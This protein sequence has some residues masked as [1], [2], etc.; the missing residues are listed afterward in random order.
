LRAYYRNTV[1]EFLKASPSEVAFALVDQNGKFGFSELKTDAVD[2]WRD[3]IMLLQSQLSQLS[4][5]LTDS[6]RWGL[7]LEF[8][9]PRRQRRIDVVLLAGQLIFV[10]EFKSGRSAASTAGKRQVEDYALDLAYFHQPSHSCVVVPVLIAPELQLEAPCKV[11]GNVRTVGTA[12]PN[13]LA[14]LLLLVAEAESSARHPEPSLEQWDDGAYEPVPTVIEAAISLYEGMSVREIARSHAG[15]ED[16]AHVANFLL[17]SIRDAQLNRQ[18]VICF[19]TGIPGAG[20]TLAGL[21]FVHNQDIRGEGRPVP[22]FLSGNGPLIKVLQEA[23]ARNFKKRNNST[24]REAKT[25]V[26][27][28]VQ[29]VHTFVKSH[30][31]EKAA[32]YENAIVF[33]E[34]QRAW[35]EKK[36]QKE[37]E[38]RNEN[39]QVSEPEMILKIMDRHQDWAF[40]VA[41]VGAGQEI[42]EGEAGLSEWGRA[43]VKYPHWRIFISPE[44]LKGGKGIEG[45]ALFENALSTNDI[46]EQPALHLNVSVRS[47]QAAALSDWVNYV[48]GGNERDAVKLSTN[49]AQFP[50][51]VCRDISQTRQWL[52]KRTRGERRCGLIASSGAARLR[53]HGLETA[54]SFRKAYPY[55]R[56]FLDL[57]EEDIRSSDQLEVLATEFEIQGL[58]LDITGLCW[59][60][61]LI[62]HNSTKQWRTLQFTRNK[63][64]VVKG[65]KK[66]QTLNKYRVLMTR[67]RE[68]MVIFIPKGNPADATQDVTAMN[69][70]AEYLI[71]CGA[72][73][74]E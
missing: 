44:A 49:F 55:A 39:W 14:S 57:R 58:E 2:A 12:S 11:E 70:T 40:I 73:L 8:T 72:L 51:V 65:E 66:T 34:A 38:D 32:V 22:V 6:L 16:L 10:I 24:L 15:Q 41:L 18:K 21:N 26:K 5:K 33:D 19:V 27:T 36:N 30:L 52:A 9:I 74:L 31:D 50:I 1:R 20:K 3:E 13:L 35:S 7:L 47:H 48:I 53:A 69:E 56:W 67:A 68:G 71:R 64:N 4:E 59:G 63:W 42:H 29:N 43:L 62:R 61:D 25:R 28:F 17:E 46:V 23:L 37:Y 54:I 45:A 60:G